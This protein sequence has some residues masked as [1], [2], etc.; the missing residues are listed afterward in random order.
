MKTLDAL[1]DFFDDRRKA[2]SRKIREKNDK[3]RQAGK[4]SIKKGW[5]P[6]VNTGSGG[7]NKD[8]TSRVFFVA[9]QQKNISENNELSERRSGQVKRK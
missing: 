8:P 4:Y 2:K 5:G 7:L 3:L 9:Q 6:M 1:S